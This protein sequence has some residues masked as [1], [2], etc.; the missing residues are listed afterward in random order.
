MKINLSNIMKQKQ[1]KKSNLT[2]EE[3]RFLKKWEEDVPTCYS[4]SIESI[5]K[6]TGHGFWGNP[7]SGYIYDKDNK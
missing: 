7:A 3:E 4:P 2:K 5:E 1:S 6:E